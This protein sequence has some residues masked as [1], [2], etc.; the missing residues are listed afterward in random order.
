MKLRIIPLLLTAV[1]LTACGLDSV[2]VTVG[3][4]ESSGE[5]VEATAVATAIPITETAATDVPQPTTEPTQTEEVVEEETAVT[6]TCETNP[7]IDFSGQTQAQPKYNN[8]DLRCANFSQTTLSQPDF[9]FSDLSGASFVNATLSQPDIVDTTFVG[10]DF[11]NAKIVGAE[12]V[13]SDFTGAELR[14]AELVN[15]DWSNTICPNGQNSDAQGGTCNGSLEPIAV[16][17][18]GQPAAAALP[19]N[20]TPTTALPAPDT[21]VEVADLR[22]L[23]DEWY[24]DSDGNAIPDFIEVET[25]FDPLIDDCAPAMCTAEI[26]E[27]DPLAVQ[28]ENVLVILDA[29]GS[30]AEG[31]D[32]QTR[33]EVAKSVLTNYIAALP[34]TA[35]LGFMVYGH[36]GDNTEAGKPASCAGVELLAPV[37]Q[38]SAET[39][40]ELLNTFDPNGWT[41]I[42]GSLAAAEAAF[43]NVAG[44]INK[45]ILVTDG[46]ETCGGDPLA[47]ATQ[48]HQNPNI[49]LIVDVVGFS[50]TDEGERAALEQIAEAGGGEYIDV[51]TFADFKNYVADIVARGHARLNYTVCI[52]QQSVEAN[53]C[54]AQLILGA[55]TAISAQILD[56]NTTIG[57]DNS[58]KIEALE[59]I[60]EAIDVAEEL[61]DQQYLTWEEE[62]ISLLEE[63]E[64]LDDVYE[65]YFGNP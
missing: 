22:P 24:V 61:R 11:S 59:Q 2:D 30:M 14:S 53:I 20:E 63:M 19:T 33:M 41:P 52:G 29:S 31:M 17:V 6:I 7:D 27:I 40:P 51:N 37:G 65:Q 9:A 64:A 50:I 5:L 54:T 43:A 36:Q 47:T 42:A 3:E 48:L 21:G 46:L 44:G 38:V 60:Q 1:L 32:G 34:S 8:E 12:I 35:K 58:A 57:T 55:N 45:V 4:P 15:N 16:S 49:Q 10:A 26:I 56:L 13:N 62:H 28:D 23:S 25:G 39:F 18:S